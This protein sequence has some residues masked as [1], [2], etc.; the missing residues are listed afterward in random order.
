MILGLDDKQNNSLACAV[1]WEMLHFH[2]IIITIVNK[3][4]A[5]DVQLLFFHYFVRLKLPKVYS[6]KQMKYIYI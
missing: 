3:T 5:A 1:S 6:E 4:E 2:L